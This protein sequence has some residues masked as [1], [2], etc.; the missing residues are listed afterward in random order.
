MKAFYI[1]LLF[2]CGAWGAQA[3]PA[4]SRQ[5]ALPTK[6]ERPKQSTR[7][8]EPQNAV[9]GERRQAVKSQVPVQQEKPLAPDSAAM[10]RS[11]GSGKKNE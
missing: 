11:A 10:R 2:C 3:Q 6:T 8:A 7:L 5:R 4:G 1:G 9:S